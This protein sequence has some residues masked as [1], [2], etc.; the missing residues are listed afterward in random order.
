MPNIHYRPA[1]MTDLHAI[2]YLGN[3]VNRLHQQVWPNLFAEVSELE[4]DAAH[5]RYAIG[6][7]GCF[8]A[9]NEDGVIGFVTGQICRDESPMLVNFNFCRIGTICVATAYRGLGIGKQLMLNIERW[10]QAENA[11]EVR[12]NVFSFNQAAIQLYQE[13]GFDIRSMAMAKP[14]TTSAELAIQ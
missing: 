2:C 12:L 13:L 3:E 11:S 7:A 1:T 10:A 9:S 14:L 5:W 4:R 6:N 8:V